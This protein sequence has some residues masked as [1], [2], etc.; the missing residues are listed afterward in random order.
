MFLNARSAVLQTISAANFV[1]WSDNNPL[2]A[3]KAFGN[4][5]QYW[6]DLCI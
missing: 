4:Q 3:G 6:T 2:K 1:N 5:K